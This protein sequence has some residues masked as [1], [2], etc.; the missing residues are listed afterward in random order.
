MTNINPATCELFGHL[1]IKGKSRVFIIILFSE[2]E[3]RVL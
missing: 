1:V 3:L 2:N